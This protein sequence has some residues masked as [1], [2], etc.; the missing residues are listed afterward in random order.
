MS[1]FQGLLLWLPLGFIFTHFDIFCKYFA[2]EVTKILYGHFIEDTQ[3]ENYPLNFPL[4][5]F[6]ITINVFKLNSYSS[7][8][9]NKNN[10]GEC[11][12]SNK[13]TNPLL[14]R[15]S[16]FKMNECKMN[17]CKSKCNILACQ[18]KGQVQ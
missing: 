15:N 14:T 6:L 18:R 13:P 3:G 2:T 4:L 5:F 10:F 12:Y 8:A 1:Y 16:N 17:E 9:S 11:K 7:R